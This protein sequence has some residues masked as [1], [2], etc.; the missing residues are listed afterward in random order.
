MSIQ[1][2]D[3]R[4]LFLI[5]TPHATYAM[6]VDERKRLRHV[7][8]GAQVSRPEDLPDLAGQPAAPSAN[9]WQAPQ[10]YRT[11]EGFDFAEPALDV[12]FPDRVAGAELSYRCSR[13]ERENGLDVLSVVL[14]DTYY[15]LEVTLRYCQVPGTDL[16]SR[17]SVIRN[18]G[19]EPITLRAMKSASLAMPRGRTWRLTHMAGNWGKEFQ[20]EQLLLTH[21]KLVIENR[22]GTSSGPQAVPFF[23]LDEQGQATRSSGEIWY[24]V[25]HW[26]GDFSIAL[27]TDPFDQTAITAGIRADGASWRLKPQ[28]QLTTPLVTIGYSADGFDA[29]SEA[30]YDLQ[31]DFLAPRAKARQVRPVIYN[32]WYPYQFAIDEGRLLSL[33]ERAAAIGAELFVID[34]GWFKGRTHDR[35]GLGDWVA[36]PVR[37]PRGLQIIADR[38]HEL[39]M[40][41]GLW[42]EPEMVNPDSDLYRSRPDWVIH[43][44]TRDK[45][46][47]RSQLVLNFARDDV[48]D[49]AIATLDRLI[50]DYRLDYL[51]WDMNRY[52]TEPGWPDAPEGEEGS[53]KIRYMFNLYQVWE[54]LNRTY[55]HVLFENCAH[56]GARADFGMVP[57]ADRINRSDNADPVDVMKLHEGFTTLF[58]PKTAGGAGNI[59]PSPNTINGRV[60]PLRFRAHLGMMGSMSVGINLLESPPEEL[61]ELKTWLETF[62]RLRPDLQDAYVYLLASAYQHPYAIFQYVNR[63]RTATTLFAFGHGLN[64]QQQL[65]LIRLR[66]L[67]SDALY[68]CEDGRSLSGQALMNRGVPIQLRG[69]YA[70]Y[71]ETWSC[72]D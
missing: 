48:R 13:V 69:D 11:G 42:V 56:G 27:E 26:S 32:S 18:T 35:A 40:Q 68:T 25:L 21:G 7:Y 2:I 39:G 24:G 46:L 14:E 45:T 60:T 43:Q 47:Q 23:A 57:Y 10:E 15:P 54:H 51:K 65:P 19:R 34:D 3:A 8:W 61:S 28:E 72:H 49:F 71:V 55:P 62:K 67:Q 44:P 52:M 33:A 31:F 36:C 6:A 63:G 29:M 9:S 50:T 66:G 38:C 64:F 53:L 17:N 70:S 16:I 20:K 4:K 37:F 1:V 58:L 30:L 22:R 41:F 5:Q 12:V 59:S